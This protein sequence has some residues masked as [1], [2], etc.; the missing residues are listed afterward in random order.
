[1]KQSVGFGAF[2]LVAPCALAIAVMCSLAIIGMAAL[3][4]TVAVAPLAG[5]EIV[6]ALFYGAELLPESIDG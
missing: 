4:A 2:Y 3:S 6:D 1:V 5:C